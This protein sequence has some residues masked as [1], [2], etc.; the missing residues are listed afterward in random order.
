MNNQETLS[1]KDLIERFSLAGSGN[2]LKGA[3]KLR[4]KFSD[5]FGMIHVSKSEKQVLSFIQTL[6]LA[7]EEEDAK[8]VM[9]ALTQNLVPYAP[10]YGTMEDNIQSRCFWKIQS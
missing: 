2:H 8:Q 7:S 1:R 10:H 9:S 5:L 6:G 4:A 3:R